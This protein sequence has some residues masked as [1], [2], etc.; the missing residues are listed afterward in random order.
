[1]TSEEIKAAIER[2]RQSNSYSPLTDLM[3]DI[4][5]TRYSVV[6]DF[7]I[8]LL[9]QAD[10]DTHMELP[11][12][13]YGEAI[14]QNDIMELAN[15]KR[16]EVAGVSRGGFFYYDGEAIWTDTGNKR[17]YRKPTIEDV[18]REML[19]DYDVKRGYTCGH[20]TPQNE[21]IAK[22]AKLLRLKDD[23]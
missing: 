5:R 19:G 15:G 14:H 6:V 21:I 23:E 16:V 11:V 12:D 4:S 10:P 1:M 13:D 2:L 9:Q 18:L 8:D 17:H 20:Q 7:L 3:G 22:Y